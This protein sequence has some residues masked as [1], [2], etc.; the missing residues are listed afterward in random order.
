LV[1]ETWV[2]KKAKAKAKKAKKKLKAPQ[3]PGKK[4]REEVELT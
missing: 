3:S 2:P 4:V 1:Q